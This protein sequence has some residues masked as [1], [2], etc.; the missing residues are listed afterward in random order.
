MTLKSERSEFEKPISYK[1]AKE[2]KTLKEA[3]AI[4]VKRE[5]RNN[6]WAKVDFLTRLTNRIIEDVE[7]LIEGYETEATFDERAYL[8]SIKGA[9]MKSVEAKKK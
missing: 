2:I 9:Y 5:G 3:V 7:T 6:K 8:K 4:L 1:D